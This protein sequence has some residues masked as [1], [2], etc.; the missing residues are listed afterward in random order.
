MTDTYVTTI[1]K[2]RDA[3]FRIIDG[4][5]VI[6]NPVSGVMY[7]LNEVGTHIWQSLD[8]PRTISDI[9]EMV[10]ENYEAEHE[11]IKEDILH[12]INELTE[13][14]LIVTSK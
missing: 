2:N 13:K 6:V 14:Q 12:F 5:A 1:S 4:I 9:C 8:A 11:Q 3:A 10:H 7:V